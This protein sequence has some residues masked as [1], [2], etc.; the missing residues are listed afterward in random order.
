LVHG[1]VLDERSSP[2]DA[3]RRCHSH[4]AVGRKSGIRHDRELL[5]LI[6]RWNSADFPR[7]CD[8]VV[9]G[10]YVARSLDHARVVRVVGCGRRV[11]TCSGFPGCRLGAGPD[12]I[13]GCERNRIISLTFLDGIRCR[14]V[15]VQDISIR[16]PLW[17][18]EGPWQASKIGCRTPKPRRRSPRGAGNRMTYPQS[19]WSDQPPNRG[20]AGYAAKR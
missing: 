6:C 14:T 16:E 4:P 19:V 20:S 2:L 13:T 5:A 10:L 11:C 9:L 8:L 18:R 1:A 15:R 3:S 7:K 12:A 17:R